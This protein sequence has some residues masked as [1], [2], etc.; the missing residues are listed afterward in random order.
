MP[1]TISKRF[2][3]DLGRCVQQLR[4]QTE[5]QRAQAGWPGPDPVRPIAQTLQLYQIVPAG[6][7]PAT[8]D[9][10][11]PGG[12]A[13]AQRVTFNATSKTYTLDSS[14]TYTIHDW[15]GTHFALCGEKIPCRGTSAGVEVCGDGG[16][17]HLVTL[18]SGGLSQGGSCTA[19]LTLAGA[20]TQV[21]VYGTL[22]ASGQTLAADTVVGTLPVVELGEWI[23]QPFVPPPS[24]PPEPS[25]TLSNPVYAL[26]WDSSGTC[27]KV[28]VCPA[29]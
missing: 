27:G 5:E 20:T 7:T 15:S 14:K 29:S 23:V 18:G 3:G 25:N 12:S 2:L 10:L 11:N 17:Y 9:N 28:P 8:T 22:L 4:Q 21:T 26:G 13:Q 1:T 19:T 6:S 24:C 16:P